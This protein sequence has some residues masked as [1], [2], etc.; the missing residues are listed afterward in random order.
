MKEVQGNIL[1]YVGKVDVIAHQTNTEGV[2]G[3][4]L[5]LQIKNAYPEV[6]SAY[7]DHCVNQ[8]MDLLGVCHLVKISES[9]PTFIANLFG[10]HLTGLPRET[11]YEAVYSA[12]FFLV[13]AMSNQGLKSVAFPHS[14]GCGLGGGDWRIIKTMIES[15][16]E[17]TGIDVTI[18][19]YN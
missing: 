11:N 14:M 4:G 8:G 2:M 5:A 17:N 1:D 6:F 7:Y 18:V 15:V 9:N 16:F 3:G 13:T 12:L 19:K 10:Q